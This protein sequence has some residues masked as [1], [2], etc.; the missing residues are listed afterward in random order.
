ML[1]NFETGADLQTRLRTVNSVPQ[2]AAVNSPVIEG[3]DTSLRTAPGYDNVT[4]LGTPN[5]PA[6]INAL[7]H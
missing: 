2:T 4:G 3:A 6:P 5:V 1:R 7:N